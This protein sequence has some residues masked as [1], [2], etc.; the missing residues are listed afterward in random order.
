MPTL[1]LTGGSGG[2]GQATARLF[3]SRGWQVF[4]LSRS[5]TN[6]QGIVHIACDVTSRQA[7]FAAIEQV[8]QQTDRIDVALSNAG[9]GISG[10]VEFTGEE[11]MHRQMD[12]NFFGA[13]Y[14]VQAVLPVLRQQRDSCILFTSS[15]AGVLSVPYQSFYSATKAALNALALALQNEVRPFGIRVSCLLP[16]DVATGFTGARNKDEQ[17]YAAY[18]RA[19][20][21]IEAMEKDEQGGMKPEKMARLLWRMAHKKSPAPFYVG[22]FLYRIFCFLDRILP[23]RVVNRI[24]GMMY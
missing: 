1:V 10:P 20:K 13:V 5:G 21:A 2:I 22:G 18:E 3:A 6:Q 14:F 7:V 4:E 16:G 9:M 23:K 8:M 19:H 11:A 12:V 17:G 24:E 15:V